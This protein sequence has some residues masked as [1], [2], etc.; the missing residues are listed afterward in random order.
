MSGFTEAAKI[1]EL[2]SK[3]SGVVKMS[4]NVTVYNLKVENGKILVEVC[5]WQ[6]TVTITKGG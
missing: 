4:R 1:E 6:N 2:T 3:L 5:G